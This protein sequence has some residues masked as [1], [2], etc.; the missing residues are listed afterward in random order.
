ME[1]LPPGVQSFQARTTISCT[2]TQHARTGKRLKKSTQGLPWVPTEV[3]PGVI[4][5]Q[6]HR[7]RKLICGIFSGPRVAYIRTA[8]R[9]D[10]GLSKTMI[11]QDDAHGYCHTQSVC[12]RDRYES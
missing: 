3:W 2:I 7:F 8:C 6:Y 4:V 11:R 9:H 5:T 12:A 10:P 1:A